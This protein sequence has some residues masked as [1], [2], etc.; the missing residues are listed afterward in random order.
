MNEGYEDKR[1]F[2]PVADWHRTKPILQNILVK[3]Q[4]RT[5]MQLRLIP[6]KRLLLSYAWHFACSDPRAPSGDPQIFLIPALPVFQYV[7]ILVFNLPEY[8]I[9]HLWILLEVVAAPVA[10][11]WSDLQTQPL[12]S[13][14]HRT[15]GC[16]PLPPPS[17]HLLW[18]S[19]V[20]TSEAIGHRRFVNNG[21]DLNHTELPLREEREK[22]AGSTKSSWAPKFQHLW[23][24]SLLM[25]VPPRSHKNQASPTH[26]TMPS[27]NKHTSTSV[28]V[29]MWFTC[30]R[31]GFVYLGSTHLRH[32]HA[33]AAMKNSTHRGSALSAGF[34]QCSQKQRLVWK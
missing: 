8:W 1:T 29:L 31:G 10:P 30:S 32:R 22:W 25:E 23:F 4:L 28:N 17:S 20:A 11:I 19:L 16:C 6:L 13:P 15:D 7:L 14:R 24:H 27:I 9:S 21:C 2:Q 5:L 18:D 34:L 12:F 3:L 26:A 33:R